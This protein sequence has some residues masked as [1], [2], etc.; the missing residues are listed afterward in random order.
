MKIIRTLKRLCKTG[1]SV[2]FANRPEIVT[3][4]YPDIKSQRNN[5]PDPIH[6]VIQ[7][8]KFQCTIEY[9]WESKKRTGIFDRHDFTVVVLDTPHDHDC[10]CENCTDSQ[11]MNG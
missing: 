1:D 8:S 3:G 6:K 10:M 4:T 11:F 5:A 2:V 7:H 9:Q